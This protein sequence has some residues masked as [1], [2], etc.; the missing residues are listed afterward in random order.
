MIC[1]DLSG[2]STEAWTATKGDKAVLIQ[3]LR[4]FQEKMS[5]VTRGRHKPGENVDL[6]K[7]SAANVLEALKNATA[8]EGSSKRTSTYKMICSIGKYRDALKQWLSLLPQGDY[9]SGICG[10]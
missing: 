9:G 5:E 10:K 8:R 3:E 2:R 6:D 4:K 1:P 7:C